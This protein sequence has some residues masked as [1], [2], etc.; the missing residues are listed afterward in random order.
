MQ[1]NNS[2]HVFDYSKAS[3]S[4]NTLIEASAGTGKTYTIEHLIIRLLIE[5]RQING[6]INSPLKISEILAVTFTDKASDD[7]KNRIRKC[8]KNTLNELKSKQNSGK[9]IKH[10]E[11][12]LFD[13]DSSQI[14]TIHG[15]AKRILNDFALENNVLFNSEVIPEETLIKNC[16][17]DFLEKNS[18]SADS[19]QYND[20]RSVFPTTNE[21]IKIIK[22]LFSKE[23]LNNDNSGEFDNLI[24]IPELSKLDEITKTNKEIIDSIVIKNY[25]NLKNSGYLRKNIDILLIPFRNHTPQDFLNDLEEW[26]ALSFEPHVV[27]YLLNFLE[28]YKTFIKGNFYPKKGKAEIPESLISRSIKNL[29]ENFELLQNAYDMLKTGNAWKMLY[30]IYKECKVK[31]HQHKASKNVITYDDMLKL[32][33]KSL[34]DQNNLSLLQNLKNRYKVILIDEFQDTNAIQWEIFKETFLSSKEHTIIIVGDPK[35]SIYAFRGADLNVYFNVSQILHNKFQ[36]NMNYRSNEA[37]INAVNFLLNLRPLFADSQINYKDVLFPEDSNPLTIKQL[38]N[39]I[40]PIEF[41]ELDDS[42]TLAQANELL[43]L[44]M[45]KKIISFTKKDS[46]FVL[47]DKNNNTRKISLSD[48]AIL[49]RKNKDCEN[50]MEILFK[51]NIPS[52]IRRQQGLFQTRETTDTITLLNAIDNPHDS[53]LIKQSLLTIYFDYKLSDLL[54]LSDN[55]FSSIQKE[56]IL[57]NQTELNEGFSIMFQNILEKQQLNIRLLSKTN[58]E[59]QLTNIHHIY[60]ILNDI[61]IKESRP[62]KNI[63]YKLNELK[64]SDSSENPMKIDKDMDAVQIMTIHSSKGLEFPIVFIGGGFFKE[65]EDKYRIFNKDS[66]TYVDIFKSNDSIADYQNEK[67]NEY[68]RLLYVALTR[69]KSCIL[70]PLIFPNRYISIVNLL[71]P[72]GADKNHVK[73]YINEN[74]AKDIKISGCSEIFSFDSNQNHQTIKPLE[75]TLNKDS[76]EY[77]FSSRIDYVTSFSDIASRNQNNNLIEIENHDYDKIDNKILEADILKTSDTS[78]TTLLPPGAIS[79]LLLHEIME[80]IEYDLFNKFNNISEFASSSESFNLKQD[81]LQRLNKYLINENALSEVLDILW[82]ILNVKIPCNDGDFSL[83]DITDK[84]CELEFLL[85]TNKSNDICLLLS[86]CPNT[87]INF[88][89]DSNSSILKGYIDLVF[90]Y[91]G[92]FYIADWKTNFLGNNKE[93]YSCQKINDSILEHKYYLQYSLY[94]LALIQLLKNQVKDFDY[95]RHFGGI[96]YFYLRGID[97]RSSNP[98]GIYYF[99]PLQKD[100][101]QFE[102]QI[103]YK[104]NLNE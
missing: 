37:I 46:D 62:L 97:C 20:F 9:K 54:E 93:D 98:Y 102:T 63:I 72:Q 12:A 30:E 104:S 73:S 68:K 81:I 83:S 57:W 51:Y 19:N 3:L 96:Y 38:G 48:I 25:N 26:F 28:K 11:D 90:K 42:N 1:M 99:K 60:E 50:L 70:L 61:Y 44:E 31:I 17:T 53:N 47:S 36:L 88:H 86:N 10:L 71:W 69:A 56:F 15:F 64:K 4:G 33:Y 8:I 24:F 75:F 2:S 66:N 87:D 103:V 84:T 23:T 49:T 16:I 91:N 21:M 67:S 58:G 35:Q 80:N 79:G 65:M 45:V 32:L 89:F 29:Y 94:T 7:L 6:R 78:F 34:K 76:K 101:E 92:K 39:P 59:R 27:E 82:N 18:Y 95:N 41:V 85:K 43:A 52:V 13:F 22:I 74:F 100:I 5:D 14:F 40:A 55:L 77:D